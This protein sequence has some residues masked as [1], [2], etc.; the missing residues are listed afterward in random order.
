MK[1]E[2][3]RYTLNVAK[4]TGQKAKY[5]QNKRFD[6]NYYKD[7]ILK[8]LDQHITMGR[9]EIDNLLMT[10][11]PETLPDKQKLYK[12]GNL[13]AALRSLGKNRVWREKAMEA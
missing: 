6:D 3:Q 2:N 8:A 7:L 12:T 13:L 9:L 4:A 1:A 5:T 10:K 11:L